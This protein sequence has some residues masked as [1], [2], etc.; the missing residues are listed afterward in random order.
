MYLDKTGLW[1]K[2]TNLAVSPFSGLTMGWTPDLFFYR[3][4]VLLPPTTLWTQSTTASC[5]QRGSRPWYVEISWFN[6]GRRWGGGARD[7]WKKT[8]IWWNFSI[9]HGFWCYCRVR[10]FRWFIKGE[11]P[12]LHSLKRAPLMTRYWKK[13][14]SRLYSKSFWYKPISH[15]LLWI[16]FYSDQCYNLTTSINPSCLHQASLTESLSVAGWP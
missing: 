9:W 1:C 4:N 5:F 8:F 16:L 14:M 13:P 10:Q 11:H 7:L 15:S 2:V 12:E 3:R 6:W